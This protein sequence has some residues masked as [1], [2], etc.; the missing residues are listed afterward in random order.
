MSFRHALA[1]LFRREPVVFSAP[2]LPRGALCLCGA[3][4]T[5]QW[6]P[7]VCALADEPKEWMPICAACDVELNEITVRKLYGS[8]RDDALAAYRAER[9]GSVMTAG[10]HQKAPPY[11]TDSTGE[12]G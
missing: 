6:Y 3:P 4:A 12:A 10:D 1:M 5:E 9:L 7:S 2:P 11:R 8:A